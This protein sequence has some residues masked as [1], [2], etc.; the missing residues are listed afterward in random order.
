MDDGKN[1]TTTT[2][3]VDDDFKAQLVIEGKRMGLG[4]TTVL[5]VLAREA[6]ERRSAPPRMPHPSHD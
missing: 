3:T 6:L 1:R 5:Q 4:W 2:I